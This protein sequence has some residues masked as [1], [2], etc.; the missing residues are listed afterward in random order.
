[1]TAASNINDLKV[2]NPDMPAARRAIQQQLEGRGAEGSDMTLMGDADA[3][4]RRGPNL[5]KDERTLSY[6]IKATVVGAAVGLVGGFLAGVVAGWVAFGWLSSSMWA[7]AAGGA[8]LGAGLGVLLGG[9][10]RLPQS[11]AGLAT[12]ETRVPG[13]V[14]VGI[15]RHGSNELDAAVAETSPLRVEPVTDDV[16]RIRTEAEAAPEAGASGPPV[17]GLPTGGLDPDD[18]PGAARRDAQLMWLVVAVAVTLAALVA[19]VIRRRRR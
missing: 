7:M 1:V 2:T 3:A 18:E 5:V 13:P 8:G 17:Q 16:R 12:V 11:D 19:L 15:H 4:P 14:T 6:G 10:V 9:I